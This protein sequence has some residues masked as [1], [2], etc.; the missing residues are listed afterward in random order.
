MTTIPPPDPTPLFDAIANG[1]QPG[2]GFRLVQCE[3]CGHIIANLDD[4]D[5]TPVPMRDDLERRLRES[6]TCT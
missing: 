2:D 5:G 1:P 6:H 3:A 4:N